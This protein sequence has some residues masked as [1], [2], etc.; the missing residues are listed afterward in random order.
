MKKGN[1]GLIK[2]LQEISIVLRCVFS[3]QELSIKELLPAYLDDDLQPTDLLTGVSFA[4]GGC[5]YDTMSSLGAV[6]IWFFIYL[7]S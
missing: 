1:N 5:G 2:T 6:R 4:S 7:I 3:A